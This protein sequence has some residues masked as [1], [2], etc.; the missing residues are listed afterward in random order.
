MISRELLKSFLVKT[1]KMIK[2]R[3]RDFCLLTGAPR[4]GTTALC[5]WLNDHRQIAAF[6]ESRILLSAHNFI[7]E[8]LRFQNLNN[9]KENYLPMVQEMIYEFYRNQCVFFGR[10][11]ILDKEP[12]EP[13]AFPSK[14]YKEFLK[15]IRI[16]MPEAK[17]LLMIRDPLSTVWSM[18]QR[19]WGFSLTEKNSLK[20]FDLSEHI[21]TWCA[22]ADIALDY[23]SDPNTYICS[24][25]KLISQPQKESLDILNFLGVQCGKTFK[26]KISSKNIQIKKLSLLVIMIMQKKIMQAKN[27]QLKQQKN[28]I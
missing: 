19:K 12:I 10:K 15:N 25:S 16:L 2:Y 7:E 14:K 17:L 6:T 23:N 21:D 20:V 3:T 5:E 18:T 8:A 1:Q 27:T 9:N 24:Y 26:P 22:A 28:L 13:L 11:L 4:S